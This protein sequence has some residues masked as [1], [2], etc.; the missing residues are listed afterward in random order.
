[1]SFQFEEEGQWS[2]HAEIIRFKIQF[3]EYQAKELK[4]KQTQLAKA[5]AKAEP[6]INPNLIEVSERAITEEK[7]NDPI[8]DVELRTGVPFWKPW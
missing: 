7:P 4:I 6:D 3:G 5:K 1:M 8:P 2:K